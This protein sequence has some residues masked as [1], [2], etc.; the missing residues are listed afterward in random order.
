MKTR[1]CD[2]NSAIPGQPSEVKARYPLN[3]SLFAF[4]APL[5][6]ILAA[7]GLSSCAGYTSSAAQPQTPGA[8]VLSGGVT[9]LSFGNVAIGSNSVQSL[10]ITN[11]GLAAVSISQST[12]SGAGFTVTGGNPAGSVAVGQS[13]TVQIQF[14]PQSAG[15]LS[16]SLVVASNASNSPLTI[17]ISGTGTQ[18]GLTISP[19]SLSFGNVTVGQSGSQ[20]VTLTN[21]GNVSLVLSLATVSGSGFGITGLTLPATL[22]AG[23]SLSFNAQ[24][25]PAI[26]GAATGTIIFSDNAS[27]S[28]QTLTLAGTGV[29]GGATLTASPGSLNFGNEVVGSSNNQTVTLTNTGSTSVTVTQVNPTGTGFSVTGIATPMTLVAGQSAN[30]TAVFTPTATGVDS[31]SISIASSASDPIVALTGTGTQG[32]LSANPSTVNFGSLLDGSTGSVPITLTN[33]GTASVTISAASASGAGFSISGLTVPV[34]INAGQTA[35]VTAKFA[36]TTA[37]TATGSIS[38]TSNVPGSPLAV[39]LNGTGTAAQPQLT[40]SPTSLSFG[41]VNVGGSSP[42]TVTLT[43]PGNATLTIS[44]AS[45]SGAGF[46]MS[47]LALPANIN[48]GANTSFTA[49]FAPTV[50]GAASGSISIT[51]NAPGSPAAIALNGTGTQATLSPNPSSVNFGS[52]LVGSN[53]SQLI[54]LTNSGTAS[55]TISAASASGAGFSMSG[56]AVPLTINAGGNTSFTAEFAPTTAGSASGSVSITNNAPGSPLAIALSGTATQPQISVSPTS[57]TFGNVTTG[58]TNS[59]TIT[60]TN[61][62]SATLTISAAGVTG[63]GFSIT[64][65]T[66]PVSVA[67]GKN[68]SFNVVFSPASAGLVSGSVSLTNNVPGSPLAIPV[69][70]TGVA[71]TL[72][73]GANPTSLTFG[74]TNIGNSSSLNVTLTNNGNSNITISAVTP[75]GAGFTTSGVT[76]GLTLTPNQT[77]TLS[78]TYTPTTNGSATGSVAV[79]SNATNSPA[80]IS[81]TGSSYIV[82][83]TWT[84]SSSGDV[85]SYDV[86]RGTAPGTYTILNTS[87]VTSTQFTDTTVADNITYYYVVTAVDSSGVQSSDS[88]SAIVPIP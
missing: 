21:S 20:N 34:T 68:T 67:T 1:S 50:T 48:A 60:V 40:I 18:T 66:L 8:G 6:L 14:A 31:G 55:V 87:P 77:A 36:P 53:G 64:G 41:N 58:T 57:A 16:G 61:N 29:A 51:T 43:N 30:F 74:N 4:V 22:T 25:T 69:S 32:A 62:G 12:I 44:A 73:L 11:T 3:R 54:T 63:V 79:T 72:L 83:L 88:N 84:A 52:V 39:A 17:S 46:S 78:V 45:A 27:N 26:A 38:I 19:A 13:V 82:S 81:L 15:A 80:V 65:L 9:S 47:G 24:F 56:L 37:G 10:S 86:Y 42:Q 2:L 5:L 7:I 70:G 75:T 35:S 85:V 59:Q 23:Q 71:A 76:S 28:P 49:Q 33:S